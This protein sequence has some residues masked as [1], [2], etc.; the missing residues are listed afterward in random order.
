MYDVAAI[1]QG[2][3]DNLAAG[4]TDVQV[5]AYLVA[6]PTPP[7]A[8]VTPEEISYDEALGRGLDIL[9]FLVVVL[10]GVSTDLGAQQALDT[11]R[12][13]TGIKQL[14]EADQTLG[15]T[16][17]VARVTKVGRPQLYAT[18][19]GQNLAGCEWTVEVLA[20]G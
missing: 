8:Y 16:C 13:P 1:R 5:S 3:A 7:C 6:N 9:T 19:S 17:D 4:L 20:Q 14:V 18:A 12:Q 2:I 15:G 11:Y 10:V